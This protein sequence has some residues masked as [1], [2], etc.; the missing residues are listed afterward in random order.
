MSNIGIPVAKAI[1]RL[2]SGVN[3]I[4]VEYNFLSRYLDEEDK[5]RWADS[6]VTLEDITQTLRCIEADNG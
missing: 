3:Q 5:Q 1:E 4:Q 2:E 6:F